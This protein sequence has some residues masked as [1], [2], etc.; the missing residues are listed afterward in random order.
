MGTSVTSQMILAVFTAI[1]AVIVPVLSFYLKNMAVQSVEKSK[2]AVSLDKYKMGRGIVADL[3]KSAKARGL[4]GELANEGKRLKEYV[5]GRAQAEFDEHG[6]PFKAEMIADMLESAYIDT[7]FPAL[8]IISDE[9]KKADLPE[10]ELP[11]GSEAVLS[12]GG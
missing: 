6:L 7:T 8:E 10:E 3:V 1:L 4:N 9:L 12:A 2:A 5:I 11:P